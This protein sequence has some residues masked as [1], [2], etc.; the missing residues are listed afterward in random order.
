[1]KSPKTENAFDKALDLCMESD[2]EAVLCSNNPG[3]SLALLGLYHEKITVH[4]DDEVAIAN[5][6]NANHSSDHRRI[7]FVKDHSCTNNGCQDDKDCVITDSLGRELSL[8]TARQQQNGVDHAAKKITTLKKTAMTYEIVT[9]FVNNKKTT[10]QM[11]SKTYL[12]DLWGNLKRSA[13]CDGCFRADA[14][15]KEALE[16]LMVSLEESD[17]ALGN[18]SR[19]KMRAEDLCF[20]AQKKNFV[21]KTDN[22]MVRAGLIRNCCGNI[23]R[24]YGNDDKNKVGLYV[25][26]LMYLLSLS[27]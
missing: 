17:F 18:A 1:M 13:D 26:E 5:A 7:D 12:L 3:L 25:R 10:C 15:V 22:Y 6:Y 21:S 24:A 14:E 4:T 2:K 9:G 20:V 19:T 8:G 27:E 16:A 23:L 11:L